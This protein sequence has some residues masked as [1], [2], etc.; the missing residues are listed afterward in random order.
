MQPRTRSGSIR[1]LLGVIPC[2]RREERA[3]GA[4]GA[5]RCL[6]KD[7]AVSTHCSNPACKTRWARGFE[8]G[9]SAAGSGAGNIVWNSGSALLTSPKACLCSSGFGDP[10]SLDPSVLGVLQPWRG[11]PVGE[12]LGFFEISRFG[13]S[14]A[15]G[16]G[17]SGH[18]CRELSTQ[19]VCPVLNPSESPGAAHPAR[20]ALGCQGGSCRVGGLGAGLELRSRPHLGSQAFPEHF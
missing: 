2:G 15:L 1:S 10:W 8:D 6:G 3:A 17:R 4:A 12:F 11:V 20:T 13:F 19:R 9:G 18:I 14:K 16:R 7:S 5:L